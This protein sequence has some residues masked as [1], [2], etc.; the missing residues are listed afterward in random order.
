MNAVKEF[1]VPAAVLTVLYPG[2]G[3]VGL[4]DAVYSTLKGLG[5]NSG[6]GNGSNALQG[7]VLALVLAGIGVLAG[8]GAD[9]EVL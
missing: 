4:E 6:T 9:V 5:G 2:Q 3:A 1:V 7:A 8:L